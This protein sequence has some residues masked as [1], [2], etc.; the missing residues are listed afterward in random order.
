MTLRYQQYDQV[1]ENSTNP[2]AVFALA[3]NMRQAQLYLKIANTSNQSALVRLFHDDDGTTYDESTAI[4]WDLKIVP[5]EILEVDHLFVNN[6]SGR[7]A[8]RSSV[9]N[10]LTATIYII[11]DLI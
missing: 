2:V 11:A 5:G 6:S 9:A 4:V 3:T 1:R 8:Y 10:A 7:V